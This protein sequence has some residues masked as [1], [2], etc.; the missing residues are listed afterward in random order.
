MIS[1]SSPCQSVSSL[2]KVMSVGTI[3]HD[4]TMVAQS[5]NVDIYIPFSQI[6]AT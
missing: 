2:L 4:K 1:V 5:L 6:S 3:D